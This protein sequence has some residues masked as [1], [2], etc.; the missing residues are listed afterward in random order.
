MTG[1]P[2][3][4]GEFSYTNAAGSNSYGS[5]S[6]AG[7]TASNSN[8]ADHI[9]AGVTPPE[10]PTIDSTVF[11]PYV[12]SASAPPGPQ[13]IAT[14]SPVGTSFTNIRIKANAN[15]KFNANTII[16]GVVYIETPNQITFNGSATIQGVIVAQ[17]NP[18]GNTSTNTMKFSG[19]I[20]HQ[21]VETLDPAV[22]GNLT[23]LTGSFLLAPTFA[24]TM[25]GNSNNVGGTIVTSQLDVSGNAGANVR[26]T[27]I[28]LDDTGVNLTGNSDILIA[29]TGTTNYPAGV[30]FGTHFA[31]L[32]DTYQEVA[33]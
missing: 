28:N 18:T 13:V 4:S 9:H 10:F 17:N 32:P 23:K 27:V 1:G 6:I 24:V 25:T 14:S 7:Y 12:P 11:E 3:I 20:T 33:Q 15:P 5:G 31:P 2:S 22:F 21:G 29:S 30:V 19:N 8:F 16:R 26:G